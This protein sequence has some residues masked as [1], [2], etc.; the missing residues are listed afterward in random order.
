MSSSLNKA[1]RLF[2]GL[3]TVLKSL[4]GT[5]R[6]VRAETTRSLITSS[7]MPRPKRSSLKLLH[8][9]WT[10]EPLVSKWKVG[11]YAG[12]SGSKHGG[13]H[14]ARNPVGAVKT[15]VTAASVAGKK[16]N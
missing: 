6:I 2:N 11:N 7:H 1:E 13:Q 5:S 3:L 4:G 8:N 12:S 9:S 10:F 16:R 15:S 14:S